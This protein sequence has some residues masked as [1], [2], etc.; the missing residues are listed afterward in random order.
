MK[1]GIIG[2]GNVGSALGRGFAAQGHSVTFGV[3][4]AGSADVKKLAPISPLSC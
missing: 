3:R 1:I 2:T 4:D